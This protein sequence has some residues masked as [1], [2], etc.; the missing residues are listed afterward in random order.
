MTE[1]G[2]DPNKLPDVVKAPD[3]AVPPR[4]SL[5]DQI[6]MQAGLDPDF[7]RAY[8]ELSMTIQLLARNEAN[9]VSR[10][11]LLEV[12]KRDI[13]KY[14]TYLDERGARHG[15]TRA[16]TQHILDQSDPRRALKLNARVDICNVLRRRSV[17]LFEGGLDEPEKIDVFAD[18]ISKLNAHL[19]L[20]HQ[21]LRGE[22]KG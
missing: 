6:V 13:P 12:L 9:L 11:E 10:P 15:S 14:D 8:N 7:V 18:S 2:F 16:T 17:E 20:M 21:I 4:Q 22:E 5:R 3:A 1:P 19:N